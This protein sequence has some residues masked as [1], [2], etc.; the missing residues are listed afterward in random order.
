MKGKDI[1]FLFGAEYA[2]GWGRPQ[3]VATELARENRVLYVEIPYSL[4]TIL[5]S[6]LSFRKSCGLRLVENNLT[7][8]TPF[9]LFPRKWQCYSPT[10]RF[11]DQISLYTQIKKLIGKKKMDILWIYAYFDDQ[12]IERFE[13]DFRVYDCID[14]PRTVPGLDPSISSWLS[15]MEERVAQKAD[16]VFT[17]S[18]ARCKYLKQLNPNTHWVP[19][20]VDFELFSSARAEETRLPEDLLE[21]TPP[22]VGFIG[23]IVEWID[24]EL[25][26]YVSTKCP[27]VSFVFIGPRVQTL[28]LLPRLQNIHFLGPRP[29]K[30]L[31]GYMK[32]LDAF[33]VP[34]KG[35]SPRMAQCD[36]LKVLQYLAV[37]KPVVSTDFPSVQRY[38]DVVKLAS[39][40]EKFLDS[41]LE[42]LNVDGK[43]D[44]LRRI[45]V[46]HENSWTNRI[47]DIDQIIN[48]H[49]G[50]KLRPGSQAEVLSR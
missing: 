49:C 5:Q 34:Y 13:C 37:G 15:R 38:A 29:Y 36:T 24:W 40:K 30:D 16:I 39:T 22:R 18:E 1:L 20:G 9:R 14:D 2:Q 11:I 45:S 6:P 50:D 47:K 17:M 10:L 41:L 3:S 42:T 35:D 32:G 46:A 44:V 43:G 31:P 28:E 7:I 12:L 26:R 4:K 23:S 25:V 21:I 27:N 19:N 48:T 33:L 8:F